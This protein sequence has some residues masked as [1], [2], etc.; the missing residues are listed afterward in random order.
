VETQDRYLALFNSI[1]V[2]LYR[3]TPEGQIVNAN[4]ALVEMLGFPDKES[5]L[6]YAALDL[7]VD[8]QERQKEQEM[9]AREEVVRDFEVRLRHLDG[10][11]IWVRDNTHAVKDSDGKIIY[12]DG[13]LE[14]IT[15][16]KQAGEELQRSKAQLAGIIDSAMDAIITVDGDQRIIQFNGAAE[17]MFL[18][19][20]A[21]AIGSSLDRFIPIRF[22]HIHQ[23]HVDNF[24]KTNI[25]KRSKDK[26]SRITG[27]RS[28]GEEF[29]LE[30]SISQIEIGGHKY[31]TAILR[32][33]TSRY[34]AE[35]QIQSQL[36]RLAALRAIDM[37]ITA[38]LDIRV[39]FGVLLDQIIHQLGVDAAVVLLYNPTIN[40]LEYAA[41]RGFRTTAVQHMSYRL[42]EGLA[43]QAAME[44]HTLIV[45]RVAEADKRDGNVRR[46]SPPLFFHSEGFVSSAVAP[47]VAK[48]EVKGVLE[49][50]KRTPLEAKPDWRNFLETLAGQAAI[51]VDNVELFEN[52]QR[53]NLELTLA[54][55]TTLEGW[56]KALELRDHETKGHAQRVT[57]LTMSLA[58]AL[59]VTD[60]ELIH[61]RRGSL[62]HDI[63]KMGIPDH[64]LRK[65]GPLTEQEWEIMRQHPVYAYELL[66]PIAYLRRALDIPYCH[67]ER[68]DGNGYPRGLRGEQIPLAARIF[69]IVDV[70]DALLSERPYRPAWPKVEIQRY[71][72]DQSGKHFDPHVVEVFLK[73]Y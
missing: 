3:T 72:Q 49:L 37:T 19:S 47:L 39:T 52:L 8:P 51:A 46:Y 40:T 64:I 48:G 4:T 42:G 6:A 13:I 60:E 65:N 31:F 12:Y 7:Y 1:P 32:D 14:D 54:Y 35:L 57:E 43:G 26:F 44:R 62:L 59:G 24:G 58:R 18:C 33:V 71:I 27:L 70:W 38:S 61:I 29:P 2:G 28:N 11:I 10:K 50:F 17:S 15:A 9:L 56:S 69:A 22:R 55:D 45:P 34:Q 67:H 66:S 23:K 5:L 16:Q 53:S 21:E 30:A 73:N 25:S 41:G 63:G 36:E 68:W 20:A